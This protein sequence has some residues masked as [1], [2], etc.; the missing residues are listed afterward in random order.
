MSV[1]C[2]WRGPLPS[3]SDIL[4]FL[5]GILIVDSSRA[6]CEL[7]CTSPRSDFAFLLAWEAVLL[8]SAAFLSKLFGKLFVGFLLILSFGVCCGTAVL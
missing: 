1:L 2:H 8:D 5:G 4:V 3:R 7:Q 6:K